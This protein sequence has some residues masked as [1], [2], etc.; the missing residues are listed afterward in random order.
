[1]IFAAI[2]ALTIEYGT[3]QPMINPQICSNIRRVSG[4]YQITE[5]TW[6]LQRMKLLPAQ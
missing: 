1:M 2:L 6:I 5:E 4:G 3:L